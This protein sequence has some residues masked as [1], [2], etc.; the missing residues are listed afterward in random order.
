MYTRKY[1][2]F[3]YVR[4]HTDDFNEFTFIDNVVGVEN[5]ITIKI[6]KDK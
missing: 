5:P 6:Y 2:G 4:I 1:G 3:D